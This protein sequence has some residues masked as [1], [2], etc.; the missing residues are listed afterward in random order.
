MGRVMIKGGI[1]RNTEVINQPYSSSMVMTSLPIFF[2]DK[3]VTKGNCFYLMVKLLVVMEK[4]LIS[5]ESLPR[6]SLITSSVL[7]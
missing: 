7:V 5:D 6:F 3:T 4:N 2:I 1:W